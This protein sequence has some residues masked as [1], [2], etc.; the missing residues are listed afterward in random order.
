MPKSPLLALERL[1]FDF[2]AA[3]TQRKREGLARLARQRLPNPRQMLRLH[4][5]LC[6]MRAYPDDAALLALVES[7]LQRFARR[8]DLRAHAQA[9]ADSGIAGTPIRYRFFAGPAQWLAQHWPEQLRLDRSD[10]EADPRIARALPLLMTAAE[11]QALIELQLPG[12]AA[13]DRVRGAAA[14][15]R[16]P[17]PARP[18]DARRGDAAFLLHRIAA[19]PGDSFTREAFSDTLDAS[20]LLLPGAGTPSRTAARFSGATVCYPQTARQRQRP[21]LR[22][23]MARAPQR[24]RRLGTARGAEVV[25][26]ARAAMVTRARALEAFSYADAR[27]AWL[28][29]D[30]AGLAFSLVGVL[31]ERRQALATMV[32]GL[33][34][35]NGVPIGYWQADIVGRSAAL[36]FNTFDTF[37]GGEASSSFARLLAALRHALGVSSF[38][39]EPYQLGVGNDEGLASG[40]WWFYFKL[41]FAPRAAAGR[42]LARA[43]QAR[44]QRQP[45][46]RST[47]ATLLALA[48]HHLFFDFDP[49]QPQPL[50]PLAPLG[51]RVAALLNRHGDAGR[52]AAIDAVCAELMRRCGGGGRKLKGGEGL[53]WCRLGPML[54]LLDLARWSGAERLALLDLVR[55][56]AARSEHGF[57]AAYQAHPHLDAAL[58]AAGQIEPGAAAPPRRPRR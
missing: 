50:P 34:L 23:E 14:P 1:R 33:T 18:G 46:R 15:K 53:A 47:P 7:L 42:R 45:G 49:Q 8:A 3:A 31:P 55:A 37:R 2:G 13:L 51:L 36:S 58:T 21:D 4:E 30:G 22:L 40:A 57:V 16:A 6:F 56:K 5:L 35:R 26:L 32:A 27:D 54:A 12:Y 17:L 25:D 52:E 48:Q 39:I 38:S 28:I 19:L 29:E 10:L 9:L 20:Y 44:L 41:G 24:L 11:K 43:E